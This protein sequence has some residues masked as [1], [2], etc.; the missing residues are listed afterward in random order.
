MSQSINS[1]FD[2]SADLFIIVE[3]KWGDKRGRGEGK[4]INKKVTRNII[5]DASEAK[6]IYDAANVR[7]G[8]CNDSRPFIDVVS[9]NS[10]A[11]AADYNAAREEAQ[12]TE[13]VESLASKLPDEVL[14]LMESFAKGTPE[15][16][17]KLAGMIANA[18]ESKAP[19]AKENAENAE[20]AEEGDDGGETDEHAELANA[21]DDLNV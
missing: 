10:Y 18:V 1:Q 7:R 16:Q 9:A 2:P 3:C 4:V 21:L 19:A 13:A 12:A 15:D 6:T 5:T 11:S 8:N 17:A 14:A 20:N